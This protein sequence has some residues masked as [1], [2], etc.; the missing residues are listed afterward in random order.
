MSALSRTR[1]TL[2]PSMSGSR[3][4]Y[5]L[6]DMAAPKT[7]AELR[8]H[9]NMTQVEVAAQLGIAQENISQLERRSDTHVSTLEEYVEALGG[10]LELVAVF[11][12]ERIPIDVG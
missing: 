1:Q 12:K 2:A 4:P 8:K 9:R 5:T 3:R 7:L 6:N 10:E 11:G